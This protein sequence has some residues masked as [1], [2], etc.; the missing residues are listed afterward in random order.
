MYLGEVANVKTY[1]I[2]PKNACA[3]RPSKEISNCG[4]ALWVNQ[5]ALARASPG[6]AFLVGI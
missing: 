4:L 2:S 1:H 5:V 6:N 3:F